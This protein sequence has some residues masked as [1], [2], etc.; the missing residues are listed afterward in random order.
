ML[1]ARLQPADDLAQ[2]GPHGL[3]RLHQLA[4][5]ITTRHLHRGAQVARGDLLGHANHAAQRRNDQS[6]NEPRGNHPNQQCQCRR[7][8]D[9][10]RVVLELHLHRLVLPAIGL[11]DPLH[12]FIRALMQP[13]IHLPLLGQQAGVLGELLAE[14]GD[15]SGHFT[16]HRLIT[17]ILDRALQ[18]LRLGQRLVGLLDPAL[19]GTVLAG[20]A[21]LVEA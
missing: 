18:R 2:P 13:L 21:T 14:T 9:Q 8:N 20:L 5:F 19:P 11:I 6:G 17:P 15:M 3:H 1:D 10:Q 7:R 12:D 4:D 16:E